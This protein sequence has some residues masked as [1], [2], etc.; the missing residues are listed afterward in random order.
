MTS[1][2][3]AAALWIAAPICLARGMDPHRD[4][5]KRVL[6]WFAAIALF[7]GA[8]LWSIGVWSICGSGP[9]SAC[10]VVSG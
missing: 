4:A 1:L 5:D 9:L 3:I 8:A 10:W 6:A 7:G 2:L